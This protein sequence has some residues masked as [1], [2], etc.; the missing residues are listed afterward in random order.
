MLLRQESDEAVDLDSVRLQ[1]PS[2]VEL[3]RPETEGFYTQGFGE[4][5]RSSQLDYI[6]S[7][8]NVRGNVINSE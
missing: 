4:K 6:V 1:K 5:R 8:E 2:L 3:W 7:K